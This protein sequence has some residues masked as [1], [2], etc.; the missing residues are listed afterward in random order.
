MLSCVHSDDR[1]NL[2]AALVASEGDE[3]EHRVEFRFDKNGGIGWKEARWRSAARPGRDAAGGPMFGICVDVT[4]RRQVLE[5]RERSLAVETARGRELRRL[6][7]EARRAMAEA[8]AANAAKSYFLATMSHEIRTPLGAIQGF[9]DL[10]LRQMGEPA[11]R[12]EWLDAVDR[13]ARRLGRLVDELLDLSKVESGRLELEIRDIDPR[14]VVSEVVELLQ[15]KASERHTALDVQIDLGLVACVRTDPA[16]LRQV[17]LNVVSNAVKF[18]ENGRV[19]VSA[20]PYVRANGPGRWIRIAVQDSGIGIAPAQRDRLFEP[21]KQ[22]ESSISRRFGG[23]GLGLALARRLAR[24]LGGDLVL[25]DSEPGRGSRFAITLPVSVVG[26]SPDASVS[27]EHATRRSCPDL[28]G[29]R[30]LL[31]EDSPDNQILIGHVLRS[32]GA[33]VDVASDGAAGIDMAR[34]QVYDVILMDLQMPVMDGYAAARVLRS[35]LHGTPIFAL[36]AHAMKEERVRARS[37]G[38][39]RYLT[40]PIDREELIAAIG[41]VAP[42]RR[43]PPTS[44]SLRRRPVEPPLS[45][46]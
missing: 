25:E 46:H 28:N 10:L 24:A 34:R 13:N 4:D 44:E 37:A 26:A 18:T 32:A 20:G 39:D 17:L 14:E 33:T 30:L 21:F 15:V 35:E 19:T 6:A 38:F 40:K 12:Q 27:E 45:F 22:A 41:E 9:V 36:T 31:V 43:T 7:D 2:V 29:L 5:E 8:T 23:S 1:A 16:R 3:R 42:S 11:E